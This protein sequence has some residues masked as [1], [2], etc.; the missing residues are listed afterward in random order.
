MGKAHRNG[1]RCGQAGHPIFARLGGLAYLVRFAF[2]SPR[3][4]ALGLPSLI[5][6]VLQDRYSFDGRRRNASFR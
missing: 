3:T 1:R 6:L 2:R 5:F 4:W